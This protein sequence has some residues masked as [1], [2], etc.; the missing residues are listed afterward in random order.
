[1]ANE[2][3]PLRFLN[4]KPLRI[5]TAVLALQ[6]V[7]LY[8]V[9]RPEFVPE[10]PPLSSF[11]LGFGSWHMVQE[12]F[13]DEETK[14][15]LQADDLL[16]RTYTRPGDRAPAN[17]FIASFRSQ[18]TGKAPHSPKNCLPGAG[19]VES[20]AGIMPISLADGKQIEVNRY[21]V[22]KGNSRSVVMY[23]YQSRD[24]SVASE[25]RAKVFVVLDSMR[26]NRTDTALVR[27]VVP[28]AGIDDE[29]ATATAST[30]VR[31]F[32]PQLRTALPN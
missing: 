18:R 8:A 15:V 22:S 10:V 24:R 21:V 2:A 1:M 13:V 32:Y 25:Y 29:G 9:S 19:W 5:L 6:G 4:S 31:D 28:V 3:S 23:W 26:Y 11:P 16:T 30:F 14:T 7:L 20:A 27:V 17:L 12:G